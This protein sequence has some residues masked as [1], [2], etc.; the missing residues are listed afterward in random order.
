MCTRRIDTKSSMLIKILV[1]LFFFAPLYSQGVTFTSMPENGVLVTRNGDTIIPYGVNFISSK[2][3]EVYDWKFLN[4]MRQWLQDYFVERHFEVVVIDTIK[5]QKYHGKIF[6]ERHLSSTDAIDLIVQYGYAKVDT[7]I[8]DQY[9]A[10][11]ME[12]QKKAI[13]EKNGMWKASAKANNNPET[14][15]KEFSWNSNAP[16]Y[17]QKIDFPLLTISLL[18]F[19]LAYDFFSQVSDISDLITEFNRIGIRNTGNLEGE[20]TRKTI[21]G[22]LSL[23]AGTVSFLASWET[24]QIEARYNQINFKYNF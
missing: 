9:T 2:D 14:E 24:I 11:L 21:L 17:V 22:I 19:G 13:K 18:S 3:A 12:S 15:K 23:V 4:N 1:L 10:N 5:V 8:R 7:A 6:R 20:K 16:V